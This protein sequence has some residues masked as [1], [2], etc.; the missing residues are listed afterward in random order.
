MLQERDDDLIVVYLI[1]LDHNAIDRVMTTDSALSRVSLRTATLWIDSI[2]VA[3]RTVAFAVLL[4]GNG[5]G[6]VTCR[7]MIW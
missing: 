2:R 7:F 1:A 6:R 5:T 4:F 3:C